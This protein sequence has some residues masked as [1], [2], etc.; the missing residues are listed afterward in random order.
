LASVSQPPDY[1]L[2]ADWDSDFSGSKTNALLDDGKLLLTPNTTETWQEHFDN[3]GFTTPQDQINAGSPHYLQPTEATGE[4]KQTF[5]Y[6]TILSATQVTVLPTIIQLGGAVNY[7]IDI[8]T[9]PDNSNWTTFTNTNNIYGTNFRYVRV[10]LNFTTNNGFGY[11]DS[12]NVRLD[13]KLIGDAGTAAAS[14][15]DSSGT[16]VT[17]NKSFVSVTSINVTPKGTTS[18]NAIY[19]FNE[20]QQNPTQFKVYL[21]NNS[22]TRVSG[23]VSWSAKGY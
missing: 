19:D 2:N 12:L 17:F 21:Y 4:Y 10:T 7:T 6:G 18:L 16:V 23:D 1:V 20:S 5:D 14:A 15:A 22:G 3:N 11:L 9:S 13:S 8:E